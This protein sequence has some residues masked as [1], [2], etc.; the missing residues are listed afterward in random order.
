MDEFLSTD[1]SSESLNDDE[2][3]S[4]VAMLYSEILKAIGEDPSRDGLIDTPVRAAKALISFTKGYNVGPRDV[5]G[6]GIFYDS[7]ASSEAITVKN[8]DIYSL[9]EHHLV[10]F[11]GKIHITYIPTH[12]ILGLSKLPRIAEV[13]ARRLQLQERLT[14][15]VAHAVMEI[16]EAQGVGVVVEASHMC[17]CMRGVEKSGS[18]TVT[19][20]MLGTL[21]DNPMLRREFLDEVN[22]ARCTP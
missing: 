10:P 13:F 16:A 6:D 17:M 5:V 19:K 21:K 2:K 12:K 18:T 15:Q 11:H 20:C 4:T 3:V 1:G 14:Q 9:C 22:T 7:N 8:I